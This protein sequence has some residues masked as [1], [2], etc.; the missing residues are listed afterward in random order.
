MKFESVF[1][2][3]NTA[4]SWK[5]QDV[6]ILDPEGKI[7][8][9][10][11][12][13]EYPSSWSANATKIV[14]S[15]YFKKID[16]VMETSVKQLIS[17]VVGKICDWGFKY[18]YFN[19]SDEVTLFGEE[20]T[21]LLTNQYASFNSPIWFNFG[22]PGREQQAAACFLLGLEDS[23]ESIYDWISVEAKIFKGG[24]GSGVNVSN[25]RAANAPLS[26][27]GGS[28]GPMPFI[29]AADHSA[30]AIK[31]GG[32]TRRAATLRRMDVSHPNIIDFITCKGVEEKKAE[33]LIAAGYDSKIDGEAYSTVAFQNMN[34]SVG[35]DDS[36]M[37]KVLAG[38]T[39]EAQLMRLIASNAWQ[40]GDPGLQFDDT[41]NE[42]DTIPNT[43]GRIVTSNPCQPHW[44][45]VLCPLGIRTV[46]EVEVGATI[47][48]G[49]R[50][51]TLVNKTYTGIK[52]VY[53]YTTTAGEFIGTEDHQIISNG[54]KVK[55]KEAISIDTAKAH[56]T[57][58]HISD[59]QSVL[60]G[61]M[62][63]DGYYKSSNGNR[64]FYPLLCIGEEDQDYFAS[65]IKEFI[66]HEF[67]TKQ[68]LVSTTLGVEE[69]SRTYNRII[70][71]RFFGATQS[72]VRA[73]LRGL[74][75]A[76]GSIIDGRIT[77]KATSFEVVKQVQKML[78]YLGIQSYY[79]TNK[80]KVV[81]F[82]NGEYECKQSYDLNITS[83]RHIF[84][85]DVG[86]IQ[87]YKTE[88]LQ[89]ACKI[90]TTH[91]KTNFDI[92]DVEYLGD[93]AVWD[94]TVA[95]E[96]HTYWT[97]GLLVSNC[98]EYLNK[99]WSSCLLASFNLMKF[100]DG[101][102]FDFEL[103]AKAVHLMTTALDII[104]CG[105]DYPDPR[106]KE[107]AQTQ[108]QIGLGYS[109]LGALLMSMGY[110]YGSEVGRT[111]AAAITSA[112]TAEA[113]IQSAQIAKKL[114]P[115]K[116]YEGNED[117][118]AAV[119]H[120][121]KDACVARWGDRVYNNVERWNK[122]ISEGRLFGYRNSVVSLI[123]PTGTISFMMDCD[124]T[125]IEPE[126]ALVKYK[127]L[128][129]GGKLAMPSRTVEEALVTLNYA[130]AEIVDIRQ[131]IIDTGTIEG[132]LLK[133]SDLPVFDCAVKPQ[134]GVRFI[135][136]RDHLKMLAAVQPFLSM[137]ISKT[138]NMPTDATIDDVYNLY[139]DAWK[140]KAKSVT[141]YRDGCKKSQP[142]NV[143][144]TATLKEEPK[145][146]MR[147]PL[148]PERPAIIHKIE[149][150]GF[151]AYLHVGLFDDGT[152]GEIFLT[153]SKLGSTVSGLLDSFAISISFGLQYGVPLEDLVEKFVNSRFE[154]A[155]FT[156]N[157]EIRMTTSIVD[158]IFRWLKAKFLDKQDTAM[159]VLPQEVQT[160]AR[161]E[162][163]PLQA[164]RTGE[165]CRCGA[166][167]IRTGTCLACPDCGSS[168][169]G[170]G[171]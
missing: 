99:N 75:S 48:S 49:K 24:S 16:G 121:H 93:E 141:I 109:N 152:P 52:S 86:F 65:E 158:Y 51:T 69:L 79:T 127:S 74:Y 119:L 56:G 19:S 45:T 64:Q 142:L 132:S 66:S 106:F 162:P 8:F 36:F 33:V 161:I 145:R 118:M 81:Q 9:E 67:D 84:A 53:R 167:M 47:W 11:D 153:S 168:A 143:G 88:K 112:M 61:L 82:D 104:I 12:D 2:G 44:A 20:L 23:I 15:K 42:W 146:S 59:K 40:C 98:G 154:P 128:V 122:A 138:I 13:V 10:Q 101:H 100:K 151:E 57:I 14:S 159:P 21:G 115:F 160:F 95:A 29:K 72:T 90:V 140:M 34:H 28:S 163:T 22:V 149:I 91:R 103:F 139:V 37:E 71:S 27:G 77:L 85:V 62:F 110:P 102:R 135:D 80:S 164:K 5:K 150:S 117:A 87:Q 70:P 41:I 1:G 147:K 94:L 120:K 46:G 124:T 157:P 31:S 97:G 39:K 58:I 166:M 4:V 54:I 170:C 125:G 116:A 78:S 89:E 148:P 144:T 76:N 165:T 131:H 6:K 171:A 3:K 43:G 63:G 7:T 105:A 156:A 92:V 50:W 113:Y 133:E 169:G 17:R 26:A 83:D 60:D 18:G 30:G 129:G 155:G 136:Y 25:L 32:T 107:A 35:V 134:K 96:E 68:W 38:N 55:A 123:A 130:D 126:F 73:F 114:G 137:G 111:M 108:R